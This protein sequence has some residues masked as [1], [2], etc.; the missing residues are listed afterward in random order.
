MG[1]LAERLQDFG[2]YLDQNLEDRGRTH[3]SF[4]KA[5][6]NTKDKKQILTWVTILIAGLIAGVAVDLTLP[7]ILLVTIPK[8]VLI[9]APVMY[10]G[11]TLTYLAA[12]ATGQ[13]LTDKTGGQWVPVKMQ[14][15]ASP[16]LR[17]W[18]V[19]MFAVLMTVW[20]FYAAAADN[21]LWTF[22]GFLPITFMLTFTSFLLRTEDE[23]EAESFGI[24]DDRTREHDEAAKKRAEKIAERKEKAKAKAAKRVSFTDRL[25][26]NKPNKNTSAE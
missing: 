11:G 23:K 25:L 8:W 16:R 12:Y 24:R 18:A 14:P 19:V 20:V 17:L 9:G 2:D 13:W 1:K 4:I 5:T 6:R 15:W 26:G 21:P 7:N 22:N 3:L 10:T